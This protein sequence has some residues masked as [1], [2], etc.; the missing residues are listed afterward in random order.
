MRINE[1]VSSS[2]L[3]RDV[4]Y[5]LGEY[6]KQYQYDLV[7]G[8]NK[9]Y[10]LGDYD[11][12]KFH[13]PKEGDKTLYLIT[14]RGSRWVDGY[15]TVSKEDIGNED[16]YHSTIFLAPKLQGKKLAVEMYKHAILKDGFTLVSDTVQSKGSQGIWERLADVPGIT[17]YSWVPGSKEFNHWH[18]DDE[19]R[20]DMYSDSDSVGAEMDR[21]NALAA[22]YEKE[23]ENDPNYNMDDYEEMMDR[24]AQE[25]EEL[26]NRMRSVRNSDIR[27][28]A[29]AE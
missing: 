12:H 21:L 13:V 4:T 9:A 7:N 24:I 3:P 20:E 19:D 11:V 6:S 23:M 27:I 8:N 14:E 10:E 16:F 5:T 18:P 26:R 29:T 17:T 22:K 1:I 2:G 25:K 28:V 15:F